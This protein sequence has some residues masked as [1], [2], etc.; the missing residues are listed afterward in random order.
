MAEL[1][2]DIKAALAARDTQL[3]AWLDG[4]AADLK[5]LKEKSDQHG[6]NLIDLGQKLAG[7]FE[8]SSGGT[9]D[10]GE[11]PGQV[12][13]K[14]LDVEV[15]SKSAST[16]KV[17]VPSFLAKASPLTTANAGTAAT[18]VS[19]GTRAWTPRIVSAFT[20]VP[21]GASTA[22]Y[23]Q[24]NS[25]TNNAAET[26][27]LAAKPESVIDA[28]L[29]NAP[30]PTIAHWIRTSKQVLDDSV[31]LQRFIDSVL[32][33]GVLQ[34]ADVIF[35]GQLLDLG[36]AVAAP[37]G[38]NLL[39][40][41]LCASAAM[42]DAGRQAT[43]AIFN[44]GDFLGLACAKDANGRYLLDGPLT[45]R[46]P[47]VITYSGA[48]TAGS[49]L[50]VDGMAGAVLERQQPTI[51]ISRNVGDDFTKNAVTI[52]GE[53]RM[54]LAIYDLA[55]VAIGSVTPAAPLGSSTKKAAA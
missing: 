10:G 11:T 51:E 2:E 35:A 43:A 26:V 41:A 29:I 45:D 54:I 4:T 33:N 50:V 23:P 12:F 55:G 30:V 25:F 44:T 22:V 6:V 53:S 37:A 20:M 48:V 32:V 17:K 38:S 19:P 1:L 49:V 7:R 39:D 5:A 28:T 9:G 18:P 24:I 31:G 16:G 47:L 40:A 46:L 15:F 52:L 34:R 21:F 42:S 27:E 13:V 36:Q 8:G 14:A 3:Q